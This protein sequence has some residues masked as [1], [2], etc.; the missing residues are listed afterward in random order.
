[1]KQITPEKK[2]LNT[3]ERITEATEEGLLMEA[4]GCPNPA[5]TEGYEAA[6][7]GERARQLL[8]YRISKRAEAGMDG[9]HGRKEGC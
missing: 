5:P 2:R 4:E 1:M 8:H 3:V 9:V 7:R 6:G